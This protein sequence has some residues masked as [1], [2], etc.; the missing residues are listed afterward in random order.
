MRRFLHRRLP[1]PDTL[2]Q[3]RWLRW[4]GDTIFEADLWHLNRH[5]A[6]GAVAIGMICGLIPG[7]FQMLGA[8]LV[9]LVVRKN[10][11]LAL[12][13]TLYTNP[14]TIV[15]LYVLAFQIGS[16]VHGG[17]NVFSPP[18]EFT[19]TSPWQSSLD[20]FNW[21]VGLGTPLLIGLPV[22]AGVLAMLSYGLL[23][24]AWR[25]YLVMEWRRR[26]KKRLDRR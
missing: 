23:A 11:P 22:L 2:R 15:P 7:P 10:L 9:C 14:V 6:P 3:H 17:G 5:S 16:W 21:A 8:I 12:L 4:L 13:T 18:P 26:K 25:W 19:L 24:T 1:H 20:W